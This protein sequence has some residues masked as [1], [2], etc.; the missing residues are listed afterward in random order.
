VPES[1][2]LRIVDEVEEESRKQHDREVPSAFIGEQV[3]ERLRRLDKVAYVRFASVYRK[4]QTVEEL[5]TEAQAVLDMRRFEDP[6]QGTLFIDERAKPAVTAPPATNGDSK[7][8]ARTDD[9]A[10]A[11]RLMHP[12][13]ARAN[14]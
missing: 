14:A 1:E 4:F 5:M 11:Y 9:A 13:A 10:R 7:P 3:I 12:T 2:L 6:T 8:P